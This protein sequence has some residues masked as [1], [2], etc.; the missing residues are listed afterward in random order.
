MRDIESQRARE[1]RP[2]TKEQRNGSQRF[3]SE[4]MRAKL[5]E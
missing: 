2:E 1:S 5:K 3:N 4:G